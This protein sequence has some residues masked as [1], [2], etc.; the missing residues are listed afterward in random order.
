MANHVNPKSNGFLDKLREFTI[1]QRSLAI[2]GACLLIAVIAFGSL[3]LSRPTYTPLFSGMASADASAVVDQLKT[4]GIKYQLTD[5]GTT[6]LVPEDVVYEERLKA[7]AAGLPSDKSGGYTL[8]DTLGV[9]SSEFQQDTTW[10][11][12][13]EGELGATIGAMQGINLATVKLAVPSETVFVKNQAKPTASVFLEAKNGQTP[14]DDQVQAIVHLV[15]A[16]VEGMEAAGVTVVD[17]KGQTLSNPEGKA[18]TS[19]Q[20]AEK[21]EAI[22][23]SVQ[24]IL[25]SVVG[26]G[27]SRVAVTA[28]ISSESAERT[29]ETFRTPAKTSPLKESTAI[30][31]FKGTGGQNGNGVLG[32]DNVTVGPGNGGDG[33]YKSEKNER[34]NAVDKVTE[35]RVIPAGE[36][37]RQT[38]A[39]AVDEQFA[40]NTNVEAITALVNG[41]A[42]IDAGRGDLVNV[43]VTEFN[44]GDQAAIDAALEEG[45][46][47]KEA[48]AQ[49]ELIRTGIIGGSILLAGLLAM[50]GILVT[51]RRKNT[52]STV[53]PEPSTSL[54][55]QAQLAP[56]FMDEP[57]PSTTAM[58]VVPE[59][60]TPEPVDEFTVRRDEILHQIDRDPKQVAAHLSSLL[61]DKE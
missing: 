21:Q 9:T 42:G 59:S 14:G 20:Q 10:R 17:A 12:A 30:E 45:R 18:N 23:A 46:K 40:I 11:R 16:S 8:L 28:V 37:V 32:T 41:A 51:R 36:V 43:Q 24:D 50:T 5:G 6:V 13:I 56:A 57:H 4:G 48:E 31:D 15:S 58:S 60:F 61:D 55:P 26:P 1:A 22:R 38:I 52:A 27:N 53:D 2:I 39:V 33:T 19:K 49:A 54:A 3:W 44:R 47:A 25:D 34:T 35:S 29:S 7:A